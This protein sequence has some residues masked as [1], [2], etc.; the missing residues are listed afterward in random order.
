MLREAWQRPLSHGNGSRRRRPQ[1]C[2]EYQP[3]VKAAHFL[4]RTAGRIE[5][6]AIG[7][8]PRLWRASKPWA[9]AVGSHH[10]V[11]ADHDVVYRH[12]T[13]RRDGS[14][15]IRWTM[16]PGLHGIGESTTERGHSQGIVVPAVST[17]STLPPESVGTRWD[18]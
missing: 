2:V 15:A 13:L 14:E 7:L 6:T 16:P 17:Q 9:V 3:V 11:S 8:L 4:R 18:R 12:D 1:R 10:P 5:S